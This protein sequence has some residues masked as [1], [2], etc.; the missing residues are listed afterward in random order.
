ML[1]DQLFRSELLLLELFS[2]F[3][4]LN[5]GFS[6]QGPILGVPFIWLV[7]HIFAKS[8]DLFFWQLQQIRN[9]FGV[10]ICC[11]IMG[12]LCCML[13][14]SHYAQLTSRSGELRSIS[15]R[16]EYL[17][18]LLGIFLHRIF[19]S[20]LPFIYA[21]NLY[22]YRSMDIYFIYLGYNPILFYLSFCSDCSSVGLWALFFPV[23]SHVPFTYSH[24]HVCLCE[25]FPYFLTL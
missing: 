15:L 4:S 17:H 21:S 16:L 3:S 7:I 22:Q 18:N 9:C 6:S 19:D 5:S 11:N 10:L 1:K 25:A 24:F 8:F 12:I 20:S 23:G 2:S 13:E 14:G